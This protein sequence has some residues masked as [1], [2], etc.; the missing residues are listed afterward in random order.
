M[1]SVWLLYR[2]FRILEAK[3]IKSHQGV[4]SWSED[5]SR[6]KHQC[7]FIGMD[8]WL[9]G[10]VHIATW[11]FLPTFPAKSEEKLAL[12][13]AKASTQRS[14]KRFFMQQ[15]T[16]KCFGKIA[17]RPLWQRLL[18]AWPGVCSMSKAK[19]MGTTILPSLSCLW[20][21]MLPK[22]VTL[23]GMFSAKNGL[24]W[25]FPFP[26]LPKSNATSASGLGWLAQGQISRWASGTLPE[27]GSSA[28]RR[29]A[30]QESFAT[31]GSQKDTEPQAR[32]PTGRLAFAWS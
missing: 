30:G 3:K 20:L 4:A 16:L 9:H 10:S 7:C 5:C 23:I 31:F 25:P 1:P 29:W 32:C 11:A 28:E 22:S 6:K 13:M 21:A 8:T 17:R 14:I 18:P 27:S 2:E 15:L 12:D 19:S 24:L 26:P